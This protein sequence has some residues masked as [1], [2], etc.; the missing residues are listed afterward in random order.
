MYLK[1]INKSL[2]TLSNAD[3][4][5][6]YS[7]LK[8]KIQQRLDDFLKIKQSDYFYELVYCLLTPQSSARNADKVVKLLQSNK[9]HKQEI[10]PQPILSH[11]ES[12]IR[13]HNNKSKY[14]LEFKKQYPLIELQLRNGNSSID[15]REWLV[16]N[17]KGLG[18]KE[19]SHFLRNIGHRNL[20]ILDRHILKNLVR[21][22]VLN[23]LPKSLSKNNYLNIEEQFKKFS[24][25]INIPMDELDLLFWSMETG[26]I[27]K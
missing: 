26:E 3:L 14:L 23:D 22:G 1:S 15:L 12:Y 16:T 11:K 8:S 4:K 5:R 19:A 17:V 7:K 21:V 25:K 18:Y 27:L 20:A 9:F 2:E 24:K 6:K 10:N 13:F